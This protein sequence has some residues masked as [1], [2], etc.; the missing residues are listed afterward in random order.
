M[1]KKLEVHLFVRFLKSLVLIGLFFSSRGLVAGVVEL[2]AD[3]K[4]VFVGGDL[5]FYPDSTGDKT[6]DMI[7]ALETSNW[8]PAKERV[9]NFGY[10]DVA[11]WGKLTINNQAG[12]GYLWYLELQYTLLDDVA[13]YVES[14][15]GEFNTMTG[16][17]LKPFDIRSI[18]FPS[19]V[20]EIRPPKEQP[21]S[22]YIRLKTQSSML[23]SVEIW[24]P[25]T[26][27]E[28]KTVEQSWLF[29]FNGI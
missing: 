5:V 20:F 7:R 11:Y 12:E 27:L 15:S 1:K 21:I 25:Q 28:K 10:T 26:F 16:G 6:L 9:P 13:V 22:V 2:T 23:F 29:L 8:K 4:Q 19:F 17:D 3:M 18:K 14:A 24:Q